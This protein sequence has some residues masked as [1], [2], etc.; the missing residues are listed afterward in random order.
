MPEMAVGHTLPLV[1]TTEWPN[2]LDGAVLLQA[3]LSSLSLDYLARQKLSGTHLTFS[4][5]K[6]LPVLAPGPYDQ[7]SPWNP[8]A[9]LGT[10]VAGHVLELSYTAWDMAPLA[11]DLGHDGPPFRWNEDRRALLRAELDAAYFHLYGLDRE[12]TEYVLDTFRLVRIRD[13]KQHG[14]YRTKRSILDVYDRMAV[15]IADGELFDTVLDPP[16]GQG[17]THPDRDPSHGGTRLP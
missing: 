7:P 12:D 6:Q 13:E 1:L 2:Y 5:V 9:A 3:N 14:E 8:A 15:A 10:W 17:P 4:I 16:P 11:R